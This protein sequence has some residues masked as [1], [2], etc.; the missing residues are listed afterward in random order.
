M[1]KMI[2]A[3]AVAMLIGASPAA[4]AD[5]QG[6]AARSGAG[7]S[8]IWTGPS[9]SD[10]SAAYLATL[11]GPWEIIIDG[12]PTPATGGVGRTD[13]NNVSI[14]LLYPGGAPFPPGTISRITSNGSSSIPCG[15]HTLLLPD[16]PPPAPIPT[17]SEWAM[18]LLG[19][20]LAVG[21]ALFVQRRR[22]AA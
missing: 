15:A 13:V 4:A 10:C 1:K 11:P 18:I 20:I 5:Y 19:T 17:L 14:F 3:M 9:G 22:Q 12:V 6:V 8:V 7:V 21:A 2:A 16:E